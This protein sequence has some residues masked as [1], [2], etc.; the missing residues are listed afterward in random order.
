MRT[1]T[2]KNFVSIPMYF[3]QY[4]NSNIDL[5]KNHSILCPFH[6][7][8]NPSM[9]YQPEKQI[10]KCWACGAGGDVITLHKLNKGFKT[11]QEAMDSLISLYNIEETSISETLISETIEVDK[12]SIVNCITVYKAISL[13]NAKKEV[14]IYC[15]LD[16]LMSQDLSDYDRTL[17]LDKFIDKYLKR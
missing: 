7:D 8:H 2:I 13:A 10:I 17:Q 3:K 9:V 6:N 11:R 16:A 1:A 15:E 12:E 5:E 14:D 4:I